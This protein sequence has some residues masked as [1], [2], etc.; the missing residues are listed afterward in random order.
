MIEEKWEHDRWLTHKHSLESGLKYF[1]MIRSCFQNVLLAL[2][3]PPNTALAW[4]V[5]HISQLTIPIGALVPS[6]LTVS[7]AAVGLAGPPAAVLVV[8]HS[9]HGRRDCC[10]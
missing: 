6:R 2:P 7:V 1:R 9:V 5:P 8:L 3:A 4:Q 10:L